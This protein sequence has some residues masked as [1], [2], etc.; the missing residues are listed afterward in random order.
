VYEDVNYIY[1]YKQDE[2][3]ISDEEVL[4][5]FFIWEVPNFHGYYVGKIILIYF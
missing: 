5:F 3:K 2:C 1:I 4:M